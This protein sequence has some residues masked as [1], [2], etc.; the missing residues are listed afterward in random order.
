MAAASSAKLAPQLIALMQRAQRIGIRLSVIA[1][2]VVRY[3][4][5]AFGFGAPVIPLFTRTIHTG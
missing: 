3:H 2:S 5:P 4:P 1:G